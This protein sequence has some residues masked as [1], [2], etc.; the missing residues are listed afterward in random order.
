VK[1]SLE[2]LEIKHASIKI[3][4]HDTGVLDRLC[5]FPKLTVVTLA[6]QML[7]GITHGRAS[8]ATRDAAKRSG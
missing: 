6:P 2:E 7:L 4:P 1:N 5:E 8:G 3:C